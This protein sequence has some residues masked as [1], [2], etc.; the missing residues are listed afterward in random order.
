[1][2]VFS[3][4]FLICRAGTIR[5]W[6]GDAADPAADTWSMTVPLA[7]FSADDVYNPNTF[8][9]GVSGPEIIDT[10]VRLDFIRVPA[11][12]LEDLGRRT[13][14][15]P[16]NPNGDFIDATIYLGGGHCPIDITC[17]EFGPSGDD[18]IPATLH[19]W[20]DFSAEA[21]E[22]ENRAATLAVELHARS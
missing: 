19:A 3:D 18:R 9:V 4:E 20:F 1:M 2:F 22:I 6:P 21:V 8:R 14:S 7:V 15:F 12:S 13:F 11:K 5:Y 16:V 17:I 10:A